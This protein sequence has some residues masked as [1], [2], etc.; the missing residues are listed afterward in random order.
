MSE[1]DW[2]SEAEYLG[3]LSDRAI[4]ALQAAADAL[5]QIALRIDHAPTCPGRDQCR[6]AV[7][8]CIKA[9]DTADAVLNDFEWTRGERS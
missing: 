7:D 8:V 3:R 4:T 1:Y 5:A 9:R 6:C 2:R